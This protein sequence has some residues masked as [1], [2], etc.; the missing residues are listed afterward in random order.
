[1]KKAFYIITLLASISISAQN[2]KNVK[3]KGSEITKTVTTAEYDEISV[4]GSFFVTLIEGTEGT[5][6]INAEEN[7]MEYIIVEVKD[8]ALHIRPEKGYNISASKGNEIEVT[9]PIYKIS[10]V[11]LA[12]S[13]D[14][15][16]N[17][18]ME[19]PT[20]KVNLAGSGDIKLGIVADT[21]ETHLS[22]SGDIE[23][24]GKAINFNANLAGSGDIEADELEAENSK[25]SI[26][27]SG[28]IELFCTN[29]LEARVSGSGD[30]V[31][32]GNPKKVDTKI[33]GS[34]S[35]NMD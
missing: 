21:I 3:G 2:Y 16:S 18:M 4:S 13:G 27:G 31:Y 9:V 6:T 5:I 20:L 28:D 24:K 22:G 33:S 17:F 12:G 26:A 7:L 15:I 10:S 35:I 8:N 19:S 34:G 23:F 32:K 25:V 14:V 11:S 30:I 29:Y 1:M